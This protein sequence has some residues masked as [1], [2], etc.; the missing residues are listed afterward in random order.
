MFLFFVNQFL[1][2]YLSKHWV[3]CS[4]VQKNVFLS[5]WSLKSHIWKELALKSCSECSA[6]ANQ[7]TGGLKCIN[8]SVRFGTQL[9]DIFIMYSQRI[10]LVHLCSLFLP[11]TLVVIS[12]SALS[13]LFPSFP[14]PAKYHPS[15]VLSSYQLLFLTLCFPGA[16][17][18]RPQHGVPRRHKWQGR[19]W[20]GAGSH[21]LDQGQTPHWAQPQPRVQRQCGR[22]GPV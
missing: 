18:P 2:Y 1:N 16:A 5:S 6:C 3:L 13:S 8:G 7:C 19:N 17:H 21:D 20:S 12:S 4:L 11:M 9:L 14:S 15:K 10:L 22:A